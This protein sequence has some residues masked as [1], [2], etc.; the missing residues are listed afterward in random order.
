MHSRQLPA[1]CFPHM[2]SKHYCDN[3]N[4]RDGIL[5]N[6]TNN[7]VE[8]KKKKK[9]TTEHMESATVG[10]LASENVEAAANGKQNKSE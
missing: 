10:Q 5:S 6:D 8:R 3:T 4:T 2:T 9:H 7:V 1:Q